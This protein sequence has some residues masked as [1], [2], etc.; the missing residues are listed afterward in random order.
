MSDMPIPEQMYN[1]I[2]AG[3]LATFKQLFAQHPEHRFYGDGRSMW[4]SDAASAGQLEV[5]QLLLETGVDINEPANN[6]SVPSPEGTVYRAASR[7]HLELVKWMLDRGATLNF[8]VNGHTRCYA[9]LGAARDGDV[10]MLKL[11]VHLWRRG[12]FLLG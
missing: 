1:A 4:L 8:E 9:L 5:L 2:R 10:E 7:G 11:L 3:D 6:D 12:Q